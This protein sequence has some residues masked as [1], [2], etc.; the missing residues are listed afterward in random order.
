MKTKLVLIKT[1]LKIF[2]K[3]AFLREQ[4]FKLHKNYVK[5]H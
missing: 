4:K 2:P 1:L 3:N 5:S